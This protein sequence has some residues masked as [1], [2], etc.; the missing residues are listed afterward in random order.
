MTTSNRLILLGGICGLIVG[1]GVAR[2]AFTS[3]LPLML[4]N[5]LTVKTAGFL[6]A[7]N[8]G[9]YLGGAIFAVFVHHKLR[10]FRIGLIISVLSTLVFAL[11]DNLTLWAIAR[12]CAGFGAAMN[13][14]VGSS[15]VMSRLQMADKT[16]A[17]GIHFCGIGLAIVSSDLIVKWL[18]YQENIWQHTWLILVLFGVVCSA[19]AWLTLKKEQGTAITV[20]HKFSPAVFKEAFSLFAVILV[21]A[22]FCEGVGFVVQATFLPDIINNLAGLKGYGGLT[23]LFVGIAG[24]FSTIVWMRLAYRFGS[25]NMIILALFLQVIGILIP[26]LTVNAYLN[27]LSGILYGGTFVG[28]VSLFMNLGGKLYPKDP[29]ILM[30]AM[31]SAYGIG[32]VIAPLYCVALYEKFGNYD[33]ALYLTAAITFFAIILLFIGKK[34]ADTSV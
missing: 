14:I 17:M 24:V 8:Y 22:Y 5:F 2:F 1:V 25:V 12:V 11:S 33:D 26:V 34:F 7:L 16:K 32:M 18:N 28:L 27:I 15:L 9:A 30:G 13:L 19:V 6:A 23:W 31:T 3:L 20:A 29:V 4:E 21:V 10:W